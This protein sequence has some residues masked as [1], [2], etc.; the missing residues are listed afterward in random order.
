MIRWVLYGRQAPGTPTPI[1]TGCRP[2]VAAS[3]GDPWLRG[4]T[5]YV[6]RNGEWRVL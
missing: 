3:E 6:L 2:P 4:D 5:L 1:H